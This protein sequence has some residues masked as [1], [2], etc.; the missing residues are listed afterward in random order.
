[1]VIENATST[2]KSLR[3]VGQGVSP[4][5]TILSGSPTWN[6]RIFEVV[7]TGTASVSVIFSYLEIEDG[8]AHDG[9]ALGARRRSGAG[10]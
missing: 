10:C 6:T 7:G 8:R 2:P 3:I 1:M 9:G 5:G 4:T